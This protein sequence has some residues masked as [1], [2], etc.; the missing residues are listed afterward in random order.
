MSEIRRASLSRIRLAA[1]LWAWIRVGGLPLIGLSFVALVRPSRLRAKSTSW[2]QHL[3]HGHFG[4]VEAV[5]QGARDRDQALN[6]LRFGV[7]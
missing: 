1:D 2:L 4:D 5:G 3:K 7:G 6:C